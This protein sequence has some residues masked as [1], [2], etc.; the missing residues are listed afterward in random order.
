MFSASQLKVS[1]VYGTSSLPRKGS[2]Q[3]SVSELNRSQTDLVQFRQQ[4]QALE[5]ARREE[6]EAHHRTVKELQAEIART[7]EKASID[8]ARN[9]MLENMEITRLTRQLSKT[10]QDLVN[11]KN[12]Y[13]DM[14]PVR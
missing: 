8:H 1:K 13:I 3:P 5:E 12:D 6:Q 14:R 9:N 2:K 10:T 7:A 4:I 11:M